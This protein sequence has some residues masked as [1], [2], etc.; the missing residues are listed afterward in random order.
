MRPSATLPLM[1]FMICCGNLHSERSR[2]STQSI[3]VVGGWDG[4]VQ[5]VGVG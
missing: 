1:M 5:V 2:H 3:V 4:G